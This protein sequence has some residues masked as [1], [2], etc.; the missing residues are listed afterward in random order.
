MI[1]FL[2]WVYTDYKPGPSPAHL[3]VS[4]SAALRG[5][6]RKSLGDQYAMSNQRRKGNE[7]VNRVNACLDCSSNNYG[8]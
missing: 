1:I 4:H 6:C 3:R 8:N 5:Q 2:L 7:K